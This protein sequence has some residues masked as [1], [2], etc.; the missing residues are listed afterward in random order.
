MSDIRGSEQVFGPVLVTKSIPSNSWKAVYPDR[1]DPPSGS[2]THLIAAFFFAFA[3][4]GYDPSSVTWQ[5]VA[6]D[7]I[8]RQ[9]PSYEGWYARPT[10][11]PP[12][13]AIKGG[14]RA[15]YPDWID[16]QRRRDRRSHPAYAGWVTPTFPLAAPVVDAWWP[17]YPDQLAEVPRW[18]VSVPRANAVT[19]PIDSWRPIYPSII[20]RRVPEYTG[21]FAL[22]PFPRPT[23]FGW[24]GSYPDRFPTPPVERGWYAKPLTEPDDIASRMHWRGRAPEAVDRLIASYEGWYARP[25]LEPPDIANRSWRGVVP[26]FAERAKPASEGWYARPLNEPPD[27]ASA[28]QWRGVAPDV[29]D[30][31]RP[32]TEGWYTSPPVVAP[33]VPT[34]W[35]AIYPDWVP[36]PPV[37]DGWVVRPQNEPPDIASAQKWRGDAPDF[38]ERG[39]PASE[40]WYARPQNEPPDIATRMH[41]TPVYPERIR[42]DVLVPEGW[43][44]R[45]LREPDDIA[46]RQR[47]TGEWPAIVWARD[48]NAGHVVVA[49]FQPAPAAGQLDYFAVAP[50]WLPLPVAD[51]SG[52]IVRPL[53]EPEDIANRIPWR[54]EWPALVDP[55]P[56]WINDAPRVAAFPLALVLSPVWAEVIRSPWHPATFG[57]FALVELVTAVAPLWEPSY[58]SWLHVPRVDPGW[59]VRPLNEP[60]DIARLR[61]QGAAPEWLPL[62]RADYGGWSV[63]PQNEPPDIANRQ[64]WQTLAPAWLHHGRPVDVGWY[65]QPLLEPTDIAT[66][67]RWTPTY[68]ER[69]RQDVLV[70]EG[71]LVRPQN[72]PPD[73]ATSQRWRGEWPTLVRALAFN[74]GHVVVAPFQPAAPGRLDYFSIA[75]EWLP[76]VRADFSG[77]YVRPLREPDDIARLGWRGVQPDPLRARGLDG[78]AL[79][80]PPEAIDKYAWRGLY[81][82]PI[83]VD[84]RPF[85][86][87]VVPVFTPPAALDWLPQLPLPGRLQRLTDGYYA[88]WPGQIEDPTIARNLAWAFRQENPVLAKTLTAQHLTDVDAW[89]RDITRTLWWWPQYPDQLLAGD[90]SSWANIVTA[91]RFVF[92]GGEVLDFVVE[93]RTA[94]GFCVYVL[95]AVDPV[96]AILTTEKADVGITLS[97]TIEVTVETIMD[98]RTE[99]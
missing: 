35:M 17:T 55:I 15:T 70:P 36:R 29:V 51:Y 60:D 90:A 47:W 72:E 89:W 12:D 40:G 20:D 50:D 57:H 1:V 87:L 7:A 3:V 45:P 34:G 31:R 42:Q 98:F 73:I 32:V 65:D 99:R 63:R 46:T 67:M 83:F 48:F 14:W 37:L 23:P 10:Q 43:I 2:P 16:H 28:Q 44:A 38:A 8:D 96:S 56:Q 80:Y 61:W 6:P 30:H 25:V 11:E 9:T 59:F 78:S 39:R 91:L 74:D 97:Q 62:L 81:P 82:T 94:D 33:V 4:A 66:R 84:R 68:P 77:W 71:W 49:P 64:R 52:W 75:P 5:G 86:D 21:W 93:V 85:S 19:V 76:L 22:D 18:Q 54:G 79:V 88:F 41:W 69:V 26:D 92:G 58:P 24:I 13:I 53:R 27:I 95:R